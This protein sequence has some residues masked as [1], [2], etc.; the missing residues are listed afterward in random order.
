MRSGRIPYSAAELAFV[1]A[2]C[3]MTAKALAAA[4]NK[5][6]SRDLTPDHLKSLRTRKGWEA[7]RTGKGVIRAFT[8]EQLQWL[9]EN[10]TLP[11]PEA[12]P[13]FNERFGAS[14]TPEQMHGVRKR[15]GFR[16]GRTGHFAK[17]AAP[18]SKGR[19]LGNNPGSARTQFRKGSTPHNHKGDGHEHLRTDGYVEVR[20]GRGAGV[21]K[22]KMLW[23]EKHGPVPEGMVLKSIDGNKANTDPDNWTLVARG[24]LPLL[25]GISAVVKYDPAP[26]ELKPSILSL[27]KL[28]HATK[29]ARKS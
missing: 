29:H 27:A 24:V 1:K 9:K 22:H 3:T 5:K 13:L 17:G 4:F 19:K 21:I 10:Q 12:A 18:W 28:K 26:A 23:E 2:H 16:T 8:P 20:R 15:Y 11:Y 14:L 6:F 25:N 7:G